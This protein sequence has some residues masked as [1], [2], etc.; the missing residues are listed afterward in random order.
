M[1]KTKF[2]LGDYVSCYGCLKQ[3]GYFIVI[4]KDIVWTN[5]PQY[6]HAFEDGSEIQVKK[7]E[8]THFYGYICGKKRVATYIY[9]DTDNLGKIKIYKDKYIDCYEICVENKNKSWGK[10]LVPTNLIH[11]GYE[12]ICYIFE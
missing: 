10:R 1:S 9:Y 12:R 5:D 3:T 6:S 8:K 7:I 2:N 4:D 11:R